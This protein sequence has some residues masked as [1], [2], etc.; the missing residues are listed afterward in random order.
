MGS[1]FFCH[2]YFAQETYTFS[3]LVCLQEQNN[4]HEIKAPP[5]SFNL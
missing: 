1:T 2:N 3:C 4:I 5:S